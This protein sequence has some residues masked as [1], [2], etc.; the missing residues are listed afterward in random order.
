MRKNELG[1]TYNQAMNTIAQNLK[2]NYIKLYGHGSQTND[3][4][5]PQQN[6]NRINRGHVKV[7]N[8]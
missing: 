6:A 2:L 5:K 8:Y 7:R 1:Y 3:G 4:R